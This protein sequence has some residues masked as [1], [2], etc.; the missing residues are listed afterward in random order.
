LP[1]RRVDP[2]RAWITATTRI[3]SRAKAWFINQI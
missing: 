2:I 3:F 1:G